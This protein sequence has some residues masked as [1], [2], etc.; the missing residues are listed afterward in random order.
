MHSFFLS[1]PDART[2]I[3]ELQRETRILHQLTKQYEATI[4]VI[5]S[6][7]RLQADLVQKEKE[8]MKREADAEL[9]QQ[10]E[11]NA[12]LRQENVELQTKLYESV[13][14]IRMALQAQGEDEEGREEDATLEAASLGIMHKEL[15]SPPQT[16]QR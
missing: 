2:R 15:P 4:E 16:Q 13:E 6:K 9:A 8:R 7:F 3:L 10:M 1:N 11:M 12:D 14:V 5:M